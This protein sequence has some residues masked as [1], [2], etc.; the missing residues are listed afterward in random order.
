VDCLPSFVIRLQGY[1]QTAPCILNQESRKDRSSGR[2]SPG[3]HAIHSSPTK[4]PSPTVQL[5]SLGHCELIAVSPFCPRGS[6]SATTTTAAHRLSRPVLG[7]VFSP[8]ES[9]V[10]PSKI[11]PSCPMYFSICTANVTTTSI[12]VRS[13]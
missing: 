9:R 4:V 7:S 1:L 13:L 11:I 8:G 5:L 2:E 12:L 3:G 6:S 10:M